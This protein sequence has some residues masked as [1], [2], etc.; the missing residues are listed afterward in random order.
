MV[1]G[2]VNILPRKRCP[3]TK[4]LSISAQTV[5]MAD[6]QNTNGNL[7]AG[8]FLPNF[9][10]VC[11]PFPGTVIGHGVSSSNDTNSDAMGFYN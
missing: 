11:P 7:I 2:G 9:K 4:P 6:V 1:A 3:P 10:L 8:I 5:F